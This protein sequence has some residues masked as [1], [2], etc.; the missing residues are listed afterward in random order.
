MQ[1]SSI[2]V[3]S[4]FNFS[5]GNEMHR[6]SVLVRSSAAFA[7]LMLLVASDLSRASDQLPTRVFRLT[8]NVDQPGAYVLLDVRDAKQKQE[9][10]ISDGVHLGDSQLS[11]NVAEAIGA[12]LA[13]QLSRRP[14]LPRAKGFLSQQEIQLLSFHV[15]VTGNDLRDQIVRNQMPGV[16]A[17]DWLV[18]S[19]LQAV[20]GSTRTSIRVVARVKDRKIVG[21]G[22]AYS[23]GLPSDSS[24]ASA[25]RI[26]IRMLAQDAEHSAFMLNA[27]M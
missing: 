6:R 25:F 26:A 1:Q 5:K 24:V 27:G 23:V 12:E 16:L 18:R 20:A 17:F 2:A 19:S 22:E 15:K 10:V 8:E 4:P 3:G 13:Y 11:P 14:D 21:E 9:T 7:G